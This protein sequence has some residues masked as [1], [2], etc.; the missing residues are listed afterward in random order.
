ML[1][2]CLSERST[3]EDAVA[4]ARL[5]ERRLQSRL[6]YVESRWSF[7]QDIASQQT[8]FVAWA[9]HHAH[10]RA[11]RWE[12][13]QERLRWGIEMEA[14]RWQL[15]HERKRFQIEIASITGESTRHIEQL[16]ANQRAES[17]RCELAGQRV[18]RA[19]ETVD[20]ALCIWTRCDQSDLSARSFRAWHHY[21]AHRL[22][23]IKKQEAGYSAFI[24]V[25]RRDRQAALRICL[26][27]WASGGAEIRQ[28]RYIAVAS[29]PNL[30]VQERE[31]LHKLAVA[32]HSTF[33]SST[34][35]LLGWHEN[36]AVMLSHFLAWR[37]VALLHQ[38]SSSHLHALQSRIRREGKVVDMIFLQWTDYAEAGVVFTVFA[39]WA[40]VV[41]VKHSAQRDILAIARKTFAQWTRYVVARKAAIWRCTS[42]TALW[43]G[44]NKSLLARCFT[45]FAREISIEKQQ[46][47]QAE[48][49]DGE[50]ETRAFVAQLEK[51][52]MEKDKLY[53]G[54]CKKLDRV[55]KTLQRE[56][57]DKQELARKLVEAHQ[58]MRKVGQSMAT[59]SRSSTPNATPRLPGHETPVWG[60]R[61]EV[62]GKAS[63][64]PYVE[65][66]D[67]AK[68]IH[69][70]RDSLPDG[71]R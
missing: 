3:G 44:E 52:R 8:C 26:L 28:E 55:E 14:H 59:A 35:A 46:R 71:E 50:R 12:L 60:D 63:R 22:H 36:V 37:H 9:T 4:R 19:R 65:P 42:V 5:I 57:Q 43:L 48:V 33:V 53:V 10:T 17:E 68:A 45:A 66:I 64:P 49:D 25:A 34:L 69:H 41:A 54:L 23:V 18:A 47:E 1:A 58:Q 61:L 15:E 21:V 24:R 32:R 51:E 6:R 56:L 2:N 62:S 31:R 70:L 20:Q 30:E 29:Q 27:R 16:D 39:R 11:H 38:Q 67:L 13:E 7:S 40:D